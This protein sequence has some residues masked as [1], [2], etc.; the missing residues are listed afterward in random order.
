MTSDNIDLEA[1]AVSPNKA[2]AE[3]S[4]LNLTKKANFK[5]KQS[6]EKR[7]KALVLKRQ[8]IN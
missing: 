6:K 7:P 5:M 4:S 8:Q 2:N 1:H 3:A